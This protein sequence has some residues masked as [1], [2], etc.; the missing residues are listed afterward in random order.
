MI[1]RIEPFIIISEIFSIYKF[2][3]L[4]RKV[5]LGCYYANYGYIYN[6]EHFRCYIPTYGTKLFYLHPRSS[7]VSIIL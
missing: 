1:L 5:V 3:L 7:K 4:V 6:L 2:I